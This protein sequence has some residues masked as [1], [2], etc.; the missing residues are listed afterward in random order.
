MER[1]ER[2]R[3]PDSGLGLAGSMLGILYTFWG[4]GFLIFM[5]KGTFFLPRVLW[6][7]FRGLGFKELLPGSRQVQIYKKR[8]LGLRG[9]K[10]STLSKEW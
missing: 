4:M 10:H 5:Q 8:V 3:G 6:V 9:Y 7:K 1:L 2:L